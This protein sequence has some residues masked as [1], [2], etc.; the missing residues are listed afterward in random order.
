MAAVSRFPWPP[1]AISHHRMSK[2][3]KAR[4]VFTSQQIDLLEER[5]AVN[6]YLSV[7]QRLKIAKELDLTEQQVKTW[8]Q[9]RRTKWKRRLKEQ[10]LADAASSE[11]GPAA[12]RDTQEEDEQDS[13]DTSAD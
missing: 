8:F 1:L 11:A 3:R 13:G 12:D 5:F 7:P 4:T 2:G 10:D 6:K 9:N